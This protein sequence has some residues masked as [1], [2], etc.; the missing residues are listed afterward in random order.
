M[1]EEEEAAL[2]LCDVRQRCCCCCYCCAAIAAC[3]KNAAIANSD[4]ERRTAAKGVD[5]YAV[6]YSCI[7]LQSGDDRPFSLDSR[8]LPERPAITAMKCNGQRVMDVCSGDAIAP[9]RS[10]CH[11]GKC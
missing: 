11:R 5:Y 6:S 10:D 7:G 1:E 4:D 2:D 3:D 8:P 9:A